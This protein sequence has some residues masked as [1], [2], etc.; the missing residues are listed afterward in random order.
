MILIANVF[1]EIAAPKN[2]VRYI[3]KKACFRGL[4]D[5][6]QGKWIETLLQSE[7]KHLYNI[8]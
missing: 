2:M 6:Q 8:S 4:L 1:K 7:C 3:S 5:R